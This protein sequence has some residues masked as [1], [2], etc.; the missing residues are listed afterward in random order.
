M[1]EAAERGDAALIRVLLKA[2]ADVDSAN[3]EGQTALM[4]VARM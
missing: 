4:T 3:P 1:S 2:G